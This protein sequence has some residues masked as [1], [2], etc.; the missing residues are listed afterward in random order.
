MR[1]PITRKQ[2]SHEEQDLSIF[3][4]WTEF[5]EWLFPHTEKFPKRARFSI[6]LRLENHA[7][8][9]IEDLT[10]ARFSKD[11]IDILR[12]VN[13]KLE[14]MRILFRLAHK[15]RYSS[16]QSY[17]FACRSINE[18]GSMVGGWVKHQAAK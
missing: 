12:E 5:V 18:V 8:D 11:K 3:M 17:E 10:E 4:K 14:K 16:T 9:I 7:L 2:L 6:A 1:P 15:F 13:M